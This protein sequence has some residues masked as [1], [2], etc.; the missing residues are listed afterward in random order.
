MLLWCL[1]AAISVQLLITSV[2]VLRGHADVIHRLRSSGAGINSTPKH[3][4]T[5]VSAAV[6]NDHT[7]AATVFL[8]VPLF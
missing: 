7:E 1:P 2:I 3:G 5:A 6:Q 4:A 8:T